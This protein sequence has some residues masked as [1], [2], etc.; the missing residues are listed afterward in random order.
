MVKGLQMLIIDEISMVRAD[1]LDTIDRILRLYKKAFDKPFG[2]VKVVFFGD[3][4]Q[5][6]P[7]VTRVWEKSLEMQARYRSPYAIS[8]NVLQETGLKVV[9]LQSVFRQKGH[10]VDVLNAIR[11]GTATSEDFAWLNE[12]SAKENL[13]DTALR[14][15]TKNRPVDSY[16]LAFLNKLEGPSRFFRSGR[17]GKY[18]ADGE[19]EIGAVEVANPSEFAD[20]DDFDRSDSFPAPYILEIRPGARIMMIKNGY[21]KKG[22]PADFKWVNGNLGTI[23]NIET[24][25]IWVRLDGKKADTPVERD[26]WELKRWIPEE[27]VV[28]GKRYTKLVEVVVGSYRQFP[29]KLAWAATIHKVQGQTFDQVVVDLS[30]GTFSAGQAYVALSRVKDISGL[31]LMNPV[32]KDHLL[33]FN[34][35]LLEYFNQIEPLRFNEDAW[36]LARSAE[37]GKEA[38]GERNLNLIHGSSGLSQKAILS[39][40]SWY[41]ERGEKVKYKGELH[42][43]RNL[44]YQDIPNKEMQSLSAE[45]IASF[46]GAVASQKHPMNKMRVA[47]DG[48]LRGYGVDRAELHLLISRYEKGPWRDLPDDKKFELFAES[49]ANKSAAEIF[50][51]MKVFAGKK[52]S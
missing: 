27:F 14:L 42:D 26:F 46:L 1:Q 43:L 24:D 6:P 30:D 39:L 7:V 33:A 32:R 10:F 52:L 44:L 19:Q 36:K 3:F 15:F 31:E 21:E 17:S 35:E 34:P 41:A 5:L 51:A 20:E 25:R 49:I 45:V 13:P 50:A 28:Q 23:T 2:G 11:T 48:L 18:L 16:N 29:M 40:A 47:C 22:G 38:L 8:A 37:L 4:L 12:N 9:E